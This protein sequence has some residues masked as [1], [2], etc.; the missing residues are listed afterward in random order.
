MNLTRKQFLKKVGIAASIPYFA[1]KFSLLEAQESTKKTLSARI[2][3][4]TAIVLGGGLSGM[5]AAHL[6]K[7]KGIRVRV[8]EGSSR[9]GGRI[10]SFQDPSSGTIAD[11]GGEFIGEKQSI[12]RSLAREFGINLVSPEW[13]GI[14][15]LWDETRLS[16]K[17]R[18]SLE[19]LVALQSKLP[20]EQIEGLDRISFYRYLRYQGFSEGEL[21]DLDRVIKCFY[22]DSSR[23]ISSHYLLA[24]IDS[25]K[26]YFQK[27]YKIEG[28]AEKLIHKLKESLEEDEIVLSDPAV[29][30]STSSAGVQVELAS[31]VILRSKHL[32]CTL[33]T[34]AVSDIQWSPGLPREKIFA[35]LRVGYG[36]IQKE[37]IQTEN[38]PLSPQEGNGIVDWVFPTGG[39]YVTTLSSG[40]RAT[41]L[42]RSPS[43]TTRELL[44]RSIFPYE[45][46]TVSSLGIKREGFGKGAVSLYTPSTYGLK[47]ILASSV[48]NIHFA[49]EH[50]ADVPGTMEAALSS[51]F[52]AVTRI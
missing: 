39:K 47:E 50:L 46:K 52:R 8:I 18:Q 43:E 51:A 35:L 15:A 34:Y 17:S 23:N 32:I 16:E 7:K 10:L 6:L 14:S 5:Y 22:G 1:G 19:K 36:K 45:P 48:G 2:L 40:G 29:K 12:I 44:M 28:G 3:A 4:N 26:S 9:L 41:S 13:N 27:L 30:V 49:G 24:S 38:P 20:P 25:N 33:P 31:G 42:N 21:E 37:L 11:L